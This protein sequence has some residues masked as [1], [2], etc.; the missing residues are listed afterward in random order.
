M[1]HLTGVPTELEDTNVVELTGDNFK[2]KTHKG[3]WFVK[4]YAPWC[5]F[6][7]KIKPI[8]EELALGVESDP[9][10]NVAHID[11]TEHK[12][13]CNEFDVKGYPTL[14]LLKD[15]KVVDYDGPRETADL[16]EFLKSDHKEVVV[17]TTIF[18]THVACQVPSAL[19]PRSLPISLWKYFNHHL[20]S[21]CLCFF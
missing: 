19:S 15:G 17:S 3:V 1:E 12:E 20:T 5:G 8:W 4:F 21:A 14:K 7:K 18:V 16:L 2:S 11:C 13:K 10:Y 9:D 6:C